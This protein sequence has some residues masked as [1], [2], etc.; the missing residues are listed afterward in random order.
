MTEVNS[1]QA[2][3]WRAAGEGWARAQDMVGLVLQPFQDVLVEA[4]LARPRRRVLDVGCGTGAVTRAIAEATGAVCVGVDIS[5]TMLAAAREHGKAEFVEADAQVHAFE[6]RF[7]LVVSR[8]GVMF[9]ADP[10]AA[11]GN[12]LR[13][14]VP[15]GELTFVTWRAVEENP[16]MATASRIAASLAPAAVAPD[17]DGPGPFSLADAGR[18]R[19]VLERGGWDG[20]EI[21]PVDRTCVL[22]AE[23]LVPYLSN[24]GPIARALREAEESERGRMVESARAAFGEFVHGDEVRIPAACWQVTASAPL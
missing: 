24:M 2:A 23:L 15:G 9:F 20:I 22:P 4:A 1:E 19:E 16:F 14:A 21:L 5:E 18:T 17:P 13:A 10:V 6:E 3:W 11:F 7:D 8:F 12:L